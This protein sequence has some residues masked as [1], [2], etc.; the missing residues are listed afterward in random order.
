MYRKST[1]IYLWEFCYI[2]GEISLSKIKRIK[3]VLSLIYK[4]I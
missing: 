3:K 1:A 4:N 2:A